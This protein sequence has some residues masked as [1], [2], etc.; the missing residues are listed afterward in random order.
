MRKKLFILLLALVGL[1]G[2]MRAV[3]YDLLVC[4]TQVTSDNAADLS[5]IDGVTGTVSF[6]ASSNTLTL[7]NATISCSTTHAIQTASMNGVTISVVGTNTVTTT[8]RYGLNMQ[9]TG[10]TISG[11]GSLSILSPRASIRFNGTLAISGGVQ[12]T[13]EA[14]SVGNYACPIY[15]VGSSESSV[16]VSG[17]GTVVRLKGRDW[18]MHNVSSLSLNDGL[19]ITTPEGAYLADDKYIRVGT[20]MVEDEWVVI[21]NPAEAE[22]TAQAENVLNPTRYD[23]DGNGDVTLSDLTLLANALVGRVNYPITRL[24]LSHSL[25]TPTTGALVNLI[26]TLTPATPDYPTL[27][28]T[29]SNR[30]IATVSADGSVRAVGTGTCTVTASTLDGSNLSA[31]CTV[32]VT[33]PAGGSR[34][35]VDLGLPSGTLWAKCNIGATEAEE[36]GDYFRWG[37]TEPQYTEIVPY[38]DSDYSIYNTSGGLTEL[39]PEHDAAY[40]QWGSDWRMPSK[41]QFNEL[42]DSRYTTCTRTTYNNVYGLLIVSK[43]EGYVGNSIFLPAGGYGY[44]TATSYYFSSDGDFGGY[45]T[46]TLYSDSKG[47]ALNYMKS[48]Q[49]SCSGRDRWQAM[50]IRPIRNQ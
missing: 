9:G 1:T 31:S 13:A 26:P 8:Y 3:N 18:P 22:M 32:T 2:T 24:V 6:D 47:Y 46:R 19:Q 7:E 29:S 36:Y 33:E 20:T 35:Y 11:S 17:A 10:L 5:V 28:W 50:S 49:Q 41:D 4:G 15:A 40:V 37:M 25:I 39:K 27:L 34:D 12:L 14:T 21:M 48:Y 30:R 23:V 16:V 44:N 43:V 42:I 38:F 45:Y